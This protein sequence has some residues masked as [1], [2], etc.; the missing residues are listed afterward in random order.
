[1]IKDISS[2]IIFWE[3]AKEVFTGIF[4]TDILLKEA[5]K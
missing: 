4:L 1:M 2:E 5:L 3:N